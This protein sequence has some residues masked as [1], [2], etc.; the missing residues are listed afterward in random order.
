MVASLLTAPI[1]R[2]VARTDPK[3][4]DLLVHAGGWVILGVGVALLVLP[5][6]G[7]PFVLV[8]LGILGRRH[9][10]ARSA[11]HRIRTR[12]AKWMDRVRSKRE[13]GGKEPAALPPPQ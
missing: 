2:S 7:I 13:P 3:T 12:T 10:W 8:G 11:A 4:R 1:L 6:P 9:A 5:G